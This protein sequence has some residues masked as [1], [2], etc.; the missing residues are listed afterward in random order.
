ML[1]L[2]S[3]RNILT[4]AQSCRERTIMYDL[5]LKGGTVI[6]P[7]QG[8]NSLS[9][10]AIE[11]GRIA[12]IEPDIARTESRRVIDVPNHIVTPG[13]IDLHAHVFDGVARNGV[14]P[15]IAGV[16][17]GVTT[18]VDAGSAGCATFSAFPRH[19]L[20]R[21]ET[22]VIPLLHICQTGLAT[23]PH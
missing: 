13:L 5:V 7:S 1:H 20:P 15:D 3:S 18:V 23:N 9:D 17:A 21:C 10:V 6:D 4:S 2:V 14:S 8:L 22:E 12:A 16:R 19:I 11:N